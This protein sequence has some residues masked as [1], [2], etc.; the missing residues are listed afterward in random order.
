TDAAGAC[1]AGGGLAVAR[2]VLGHRGDP[3][4]HGG[5][6]SAGVRRRIKKRASAKLVDRAGWGGQRGEPRRGG[7]PRLSRPPLG[8]GR[9]HSPQFQD[10]SRGMTENTAMQ[11][12]VMSREENALKFDG[13]I[14]IVAGAGGGG[15]GTT[16]AATLARAGATVVAVSRSRANL[17][18]HIA[19]LA[20]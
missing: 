2:D 14:V 20:M 9:S 11:K 8:A 17:D 19:P 13:R 5:T 1:G 12:A 6:R 15:I 18:R 4:L 16:V 7:T 3:H 10:G